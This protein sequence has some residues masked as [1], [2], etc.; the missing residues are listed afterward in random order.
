MFYWWQFRVPCEHGS[1]LFRELDC[2]P[3]V[4]VMWVLLDVKLHEL[5]MAET[6]RGL[7]VVEKKLV[8]LEVYKT[9]P[10]RLESFHS[11]SVQSRWI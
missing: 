11:S 4:R 2:N 8:P 9:I 3:L 7:A 6:G 5:S 10:L 1:C